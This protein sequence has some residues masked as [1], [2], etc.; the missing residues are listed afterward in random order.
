M[1]RDFCEK[2]VNVMLR[3]KCLCS[4]AAETPGEAL[5]GEFLGDEEG[6]CVVCG[7]VVGS[8]CII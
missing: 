1:S 8:G 5:V 4:E 3:G 2:D 7:C 6:I